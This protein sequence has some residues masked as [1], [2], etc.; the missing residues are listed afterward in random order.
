M[1]ALQTNLPAI[2]AS[3]FCN[4]ENKAILFVKHGNKNFIDYTDGNDMAAWIADAL[5]IGSKVY[6]YNAWHE[7]D[8][9]LKDYFREVLRDSLENI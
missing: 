1:R 5:C 8:D 2:P 4:K 3:V 7:I 6:A 9:T